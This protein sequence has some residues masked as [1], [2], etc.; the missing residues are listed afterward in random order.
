MKAFQRTLY[1]IQIFSL[2]SVILLIRKLT[3]RQAIL[4]GRFMGLIT[5]VCLPLHRKIS[6]MQMRSA[7]GPDVDVK[8]LTR[9]VFMNQ[10]DVIVDM[11]RFAYMD[12]QELKN[13]IIIEGREHIEEAISTGRGVM[14]IT[15][16]MNWEI[17]GHLPRLMGID[18]SIMGDVIKSEAIQSVIEDLRSKCGFTLLPPK[19]GM[20]AML[21]NELRKGKIIG[22]MMDQR[23][24]RENKI[25]CDFLG[26]PAP[27]NPGPALIVLKGD[28]LIQPV[29]ATKEGNNY[30]F[31]FHKYIDS[32]DFGNDYEGILHL[33]DCWKSRSIQQVSDIMQSWVCT[34]IRKDPD[35]W[36]WLHTKWLRKADMKRI[37]KEDLDFKEQVLLQADKYLS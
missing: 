24:K 1:F 36:F 15:G 8:N 17:L 10:G 7:L 35:Q 4:L 18:F 28:A 32:R 23:G 5:S 22:I 27:T 12:N 19:G 11:I 16:H 34:V 2:K 26:M 29:S 14:M 33:N 30:R 6:Q 20:V 21:S 3:Y 31:C 25:F 9:K 13:R 37:I